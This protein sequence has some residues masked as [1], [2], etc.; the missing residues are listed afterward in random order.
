MDTSEM[1]F[2]IEINFEICCSVVFPQFLLLLII[3][4]N[5]VVVVVGSVE[6]GIR[7]LSAVLLYNYTWGR[8]GEGR[9]IKGQFIHIYRKIVFHPQR[10]HREICF[11]PRIYFG[12]A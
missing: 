11:V 8:F 1:L 7:V 4:L 5:T 3:N 9:R 12:S 10:I 2:L 6:K